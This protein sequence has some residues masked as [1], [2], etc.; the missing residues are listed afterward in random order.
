MGK[1]KLFVYKNEDKTV[2][3]NYNGIDIEGNDYTITGLNDNTEYIIKMRRYNEDETLLSNVSKSKIVKTDSAMIENID[4][5]N[6]T[7]NSCNIV[8]DNINHVNTYEIYLYNTNKELIDTYP[9]NKLTNEFSLT[10]LIPNTDYIIKIR[11]KYNDNNSFS[12][13]SSGK[14]FKTQELILSTPVIT[15]MSQTTNNSIKININPVQHATDYNIYV[16]KDNILLENFPIAT[17][18]LENT[19]NGL[20]PDTNY[21]IKVKA[22]YLTYVES[23]FS[24]ELS[25]T[26]LENGNSGSNEVYD[27]NINPVLPIPYEITIDYMDFGS[28]NLRFSLSE[29]G[30]LENNDPAIEKGAYIFVYDVNNNLLFIVNEVY[31]YGNYGGEFVYITYIYNEQ[32]DI[33]GDIIDDLLNDFVYKVKMKSYVKDLTNETIEFS[34]Y[35][36]EF[37]FSFKNSLDS[38]IPSTDMKLDLFYPNELSSES[39][40]NV[41]DTNVN[42]NLWSNNKNLEPAIDEYVFKID[43]KIIKNDNTIVFNEDG[44]QDKYDDFNYDSFGNDYISSNY[45]KNNDKIKIEMFKKAR[46]NTTSEEWQSE[47]S[48]IKFLVEGSDYILYSDA[49]S[50]SSI[51][52]LYSRTIDGYSFMSL[53][54][55]YG[56]FYPSSY[57]YPYNDILPKGDHS[58]EFIFFSRM[59]E[60]TGFRE[61]YYTLSNGE[62][63]PEDVKDR[64]VISDSSAHCMTDGFIHNGF[65]YFVKENTSNERNLFRVRFNGTDLEQLTTTN[66]VTMACQSIHEEIDDE[67]FILEYNNNIVSST[68]EY[69]VASNVFNQVINTSNVRYISVGDDG[70][71]YLS[72]LDDLY[73]YYSVYKM[74]RDGS[75]LEKIFSPNKHINNPQVVDGLLF[76]TEATYY[77][78]YSYV[79]DLIDLNPLTNR[80]NSFS[81]S[82]GNLFLGKYKQ[83]VSNL[84]PSILNVDISN[85]DEITILVSDIE[86]VT[87][88]FVTVYYATQEF[89]IFTNRKQIMFTWDSTDPSSIMTTNNGTSTITIKNNLIKNNSKFHIAVQ[90]KDSITNLYTKKRYEYVSKGL[91]QIENYIVIAYDDNSLKSY[92]MNMQEEEGF[93]FKNCYNAQRY[94]KK[95]RDLIIV[96]DE[97]YI[98]YTMYSLFQDNQP[99]A[100]YISRIDKGYIQDVKNNNLYVKKPIMDDYYGTTTYNEFRHYLNYLKDY[101]N[102]YYYGVG[103]NYDKTESKIYKKNELHEFEHITTNNANPVDIKVFYG[104]SLNE[105]VFYQYMNNGFFKTNIINKVNGVT[106]EIA[107]NYNNLKNIHIV[108]YETFYAIVNNVLAIFKYDL[109]NDTFNVNSYITIDLG[110]IS[111][112]Q[113]CFHNN[114]IYFLTLDKK[115]KKLSL[116]NI[117]LESFTNAELESNIALLAEGVEDFAISVGSE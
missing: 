86:N 82:S 54:N 11:T 114:S 51:Y 64:L 65:V 115:F 42:D 78:V 58:G 53:S 67:Y 96:P 1:F 23:N 47:T 71:L 19:I 83:N 29:N 14:L 55:P 68:L 112:A 62:K 5:A 20:E 7:F 34:E 101:A 113:H 31:D 109:D 93:R 2:L 38:I 52:I 22:R 30:W 104:D 57:Y 33:N 13:I 84:M 59:N 91:Y 48:E 18:T 73:G 3:N 88:T 107:T 4:T 12:L 103:Y 116:D 106:T 32:I 43:T 6:I 90:Q 66:I 69:P 16:Y 17:N 49:K 70:Y 9:I 81:S 79:K 56:L 10:N 111:K 110:G 36:E 41:Y 100:F 80:D 95:P 21:Q 44:I 60:S 87:E 99:D 102:G 92:N 46:N 75:N 45:F 76:Y 40:T 15:D 105:K 35:S 97:D 39:W 63:F 37:S 61:I 108:D 8:C 85:R 50:Y 25:I 117:S 98:A 77:D 74:N 28:V 24:N 27:T 72:K 89:D 26:T 94:E